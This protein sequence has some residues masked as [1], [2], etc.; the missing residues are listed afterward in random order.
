MNLREF[1]EQARSLHS[2][3]TIDG[4]PIEDAELRRMS[5]KLL[6]E[7]RKASHKE[8]GWDGSVLGFLLWK[9]DLLRSERECRFCRCEPRPAFGEGACR[10]RKA[11]HAF[12]TFHELDLVSLSHTVGLRRV[13]LW[14]KD[15]DKGGKRRPR[16]LEGL[17][18]MYGKF[19]AAVVS[20]RPELSKQAC[21]MEAAD[22]FQRMLYRAAGKGGWMAQEKDGT[23]R[24]TDDRLLDVIVRITSTVAEAKV[25]VA[26]LAEEAANTALGSE[27]GGTSIW[28]KIRNLFGK[29]K[30][31]LGNCFDGVKIILKISLA[32]ALTVHIFGWKAIRS[33]GG[34]LSLKWWEALL[35]IL[36]ALVTLPGNLVYHG[37]L[38]LW[39]AMCWLFGPEPSG[40]R[41]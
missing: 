1:V 27:D 12:Y 18:D 17:A 23:I 6:N 2:A 13:L 36:I 41:A 4:V 14:M 35:T 38:A 33:P 24:Q 20:T 40:A 39:D 19:L 15:W 9:D 30:R 5:R 32:V 26:E 7:A 21:R 29:V 22:Q 8:E 3:G 37:A 34:I 28:W 16:A 25:S 10:C 11:L 31:L